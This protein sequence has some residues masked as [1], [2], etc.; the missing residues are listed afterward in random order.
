MST[1]DERAARRDIT[2]VANVV[3]PEDNKPNLPILTPEAGLSNFLAF[4]MLNSPAVEAAYY[5]W[6][7]SVE[8]V[9]VA[10]SLV[11]LNSFKKRMSMS[12]ETV[13]GAVDVAVI[14]KG[15]G[16]IWIDRKHYF[17][18]ALN[19]HFVHNRFPNAT[20]VRKAEDD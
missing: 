2:S 16:F 5:D 18:P 13:G 15:D 17:D 6:V 11:N 19:P 7:S 20:S 10:R 8:Q 1:P 12:L 9:T 14:S 3:R 4:A